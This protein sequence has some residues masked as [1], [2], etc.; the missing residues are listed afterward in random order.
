[1]TQ[2]TDIEK[3]SKVLAERREALKLYVNSLQSGLEA[4]KK[5]HLPAIRKALDQAE[6]AHGALLQLVRDNPELFA[7]P[8]SQTFHNIRCGYRKQPGQMVIGDAKKVVERIE[9]MFDGNDEVLAQLLI[10]TK[11]PSV[12]GLESLDAATLKKLGV[13]VTHDS[14]VAFVK[15]LD[16]ELDTLVKTAVGGE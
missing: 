11:R 9:K 3:A 2:L 15:A 7:K 12:E 6:T 16:T 4:L 14:D 8:K 13:T 1:M 10:T 5:Q